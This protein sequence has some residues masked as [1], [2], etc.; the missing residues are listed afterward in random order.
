MATLY[1]PDLADTCVLQRRHLRRTWSLHVPKTQRLHIQIAVERIVAA[2]PEDAAR[3]QYLWRELAAAYEVRGCCLPAEQV[4]NPASHTYFTAPAAW[5]PCPRDIDIACAE[6]GDDVPLARPRFWCRLC[7]QASPD[8][9][10]WAKHLQ[11]ARGGPLAYRQTLLDALAAQWPAP[12]SPAH[13][14]QCMDSYARSFQALL[15]LPKRLLLCIRGPI[16]IRGPRPLV[17]DS[18]PSGFSSIMD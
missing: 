3:F 11:D 15:D 12:T 14:R 8:E 16:H 17:E 10:T 5:A 1:D 9:I 18:I 4:F 6:N 2:C 13:V 7:G